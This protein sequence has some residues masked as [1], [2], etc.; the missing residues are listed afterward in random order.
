MKNI[1]VLSETFQFLQVKFSVYLNRL[2]FVMILVAPDK[3]LFN[4][5]V[6]ILFLHYENTPIQIQSTHVISK[7][8]G[9]SGI[10]RDFRT[11]TY[12]ICGIEENNKSN[13]I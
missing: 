9:L 4:Q 1:R 5:N 13:N 8:K 11:S 10:L 3:A 7:S 12:Q 2:V 6:L